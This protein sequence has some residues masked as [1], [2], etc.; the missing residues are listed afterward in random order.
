MNCAS[1]VRFIFFL[2]KKA[3]IHQPKSFHGQVNLT[4]LFTLKKCFDVEI[5]TTLDR[6]TK[7]LMNVCKIKSMRCFFLVLKCSK[8][9]QAF[10]FL[11]KL[12][13]GS[14]AINFETRQLFKTFKILFKL[15][16]CQISLMDFF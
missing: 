4:L 8:R 2:K 10:F 13:T 6:S 16:R 12:R 3:D 11:K 15:Q 14:G 1:S 9:E 5:F 7:S